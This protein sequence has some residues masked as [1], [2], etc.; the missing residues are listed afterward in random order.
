MDTMG[1]RID[2]VVAC[3]LECS[4]ERKGLS[5]DHDMMH[6]FLEECEGKC[7]EELQYVLSAWLNAQTV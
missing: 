3:L 6:R 2:G 4:V 7:V 5:Y 1:G